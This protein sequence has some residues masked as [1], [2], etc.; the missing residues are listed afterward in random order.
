MSQ[1]SSLGT[2]IFSVKQNVKNTLKLEV[3][4]AEG[5]ASH[6]GVLVKSSGIY[7]LASL[8]VPLVTLVLAPFLTHTLSLADYGVLAV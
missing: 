2:R 6:I 4:D 7:A 8:T 3:R 1:V 5:D